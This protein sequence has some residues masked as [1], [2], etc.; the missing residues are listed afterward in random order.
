MLDTLR[1]STRVDI[2]Y[3]NVLYGWKGERTKKGIHSI[4][5]FIPL[6]NGA[7]IYMKLYTWTQY[8]VIQF[9]ASKVL[10]GDNIDAYDFEKFYFV[11]KTIEYVINKKLGVR[12]KTSNFKLTRL[13]LNRDFIYN[14]EET[15]DKVLGF[16]RKILPGRC[17]HRV[18]YEFG[19]TSLTR[20]ATGFRVYRKDKDEHLTE[21]QRSKMLPTLRFEFQ[22]NRR[23]IERIFKCRPSL[24]QV[25]KNHMLVSIAWNRVLM[26]YALDKAI[27]NKHHLYIEARKYLTNSEFLTLKQMNETPSFNDKDLRK[28]QLAVIRKLKKVG[29][30]PYA[31]EV[32]I[33]VTI[34]IR[35]LIK[36]LHRKKNESC[37][38]K[39]QHKTRR[40]YVLIDTN[41]TVV[42][43]YLDSS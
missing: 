10:N 33:Q 30:C 24:H 22:L 5:R 15:A 36:T 11:E 16:A 38:H 20:H 2:T 43:W 32:S 3:Y 35:H 21:E 41:D 31:C 7:I 9:S 29:I 4:S 28:K 40:N 39:K 25:L 37:R 17:E 34:S 42:R 13:D 1:A 27:L 18:D 12:L 26:L 19:F 14:D 8:F 6:S 23:R